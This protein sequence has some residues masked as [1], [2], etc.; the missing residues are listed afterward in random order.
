VVLRNVQSETLEKF[1]K[2]ILRNVQ[3]C[4][5]KIANVK[6]TQPKKTIIIFLRNFS[7]VS[8]CLN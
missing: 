2:N 4:C 8:D 3:V 7:K 5:C 6:L 1:R